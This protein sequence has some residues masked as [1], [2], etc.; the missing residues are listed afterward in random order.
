MGKAL[1]GEIFYVDTFGNLIANID[2]DQFS[3][4]TEARSPVIKVAKERMYG[5]KKGYS[6]GKRGETMA[7]LGSSGFLEVCVREGDAREK[8]KVKKGDPVRVE[9]P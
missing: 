2:E 7:L 5:L 8:L 9:I 1:V 6:F 4:F 3:R